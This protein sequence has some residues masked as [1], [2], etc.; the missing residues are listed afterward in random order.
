MISGFNTDIVHEGVTYHVQTEDKGIATPVIL[1]LVYEGGT[2]LAS[3]RS[4]YSDLIDGGLDDKALND[5]LQRQ[6]KLI[7]AAIKGGRLGDLRQMSARE[8]EPILTIQPL[9]ELPDSSEKPQPDEPFNPNITLKIPVESII[10]TDEDFVDLLPVEPRILAESK[11]ELFQPVVVEPAALVAFRETTTV[12]QAQVDNFD[13]STDPFETEARRIPK[14]EERLQVTI[15]VIV[16]EEPILPAEAVAIITGNLGK[17][18]PL[19]NELSIRLQDRSEFVGGT[20][21]TLRISVHK[22]ENREGL[23]KAHVIIKILGSSFR[24]IIFHAKT[25]ADGFAI[26]HLQLPDF[27]SGRAVLL[28]RVLHEGEETE[29]RLPIIQ[30]MERRP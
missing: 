11:P 1:S 10:E 27:T 16:D 9:E 19:P 22:G 30:N 8:S 12:L 18:N 4:N 24:P 13:A 2:I 26:V 29:V 15:P 3:K 6:H 20:Q 23:V 25:D 28:I 5:R 17:S 21:R 7:C 14:P